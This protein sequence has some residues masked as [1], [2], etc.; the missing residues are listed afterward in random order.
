MDKDISRVAVERAAAT[1]VRVKRAVQG[2]IPYGPSKVKLTASELRRTLQS[3]GPDSITRLMQY[4]GPE[5]AMQMLLGA[6][7][8]MPPTLESFVEEQNAGSQ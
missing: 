6:R 3:S 1:L 7:K 5:Q 8:N 2:T 4:L